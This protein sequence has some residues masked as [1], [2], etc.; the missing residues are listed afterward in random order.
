MADKPITA[1]FTDKDA[2][3]GAATDLHTLRVRDISIERMEDD[4]PEGYHPFVAGTFGVPQGS[5]PM[6][7]GAYNGQN[8][9]MMSA[10]IDGYLE[11]TSY[12]N[13]TGDRKDEQRKVMLSFHV[14]EQDA[15]QA[16]AMI[17][18]A[19]GDIQDI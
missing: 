14:D 3:E 10:G 7:M 13:E 19:R 8:L 18:K 5:A 6:N 2:A 9:V 15:D 12:K 16:I 4:R 1:F 11:E 17:Q